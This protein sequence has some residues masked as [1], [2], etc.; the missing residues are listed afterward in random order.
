MTLGSVQKLHDY[1]IGDYITHQ[2]EEHSGCLNTILSFTKSVIVEDLF[3]KTLKQTI[4]Q[5][6]FFKKLNNIFQSIYFD[7]LTIS[8]LMADEVLPEIIN[9]IDYAELVEHMVTSST[10]QNLTGALTI[11]NLETDI[12]DAKLVNGMSVKELKQLLLDAQSLYN[13]LFNSNTS[14]KSLQVTGMITASSINGNNILDIFDKDN[15]ATVIFNKGV[16]IEDLTV[17]GFV[18][19]LNF[20]EFISD[21]VLKTD[22][23]VTFTGFKIFEN[24][25]CEVL[26]TLLINGHSVDDILSADKEQVLKGPIVVNGI[27][28][29]LI[30]NIQK[31]FVIFLLIRRRM[32]IKI[33]MYFLRFGHRFKHLQYNRK[34]W[35][36]VFPRF[37]R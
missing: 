15:M 27:L 28:C 17:K 19:G 29:T 18:N 4:S 22:R 9:G 21:A 32:L 5:T 30:H 16:S 24:V 10:R 6:S 14:I 8:T 7:N 31:V 37:H 1:V 2:H 34:N 12:L 20:S 23:N 35:K 26:E 11:N 25:T 13:D 3:F 36:C 33:Y